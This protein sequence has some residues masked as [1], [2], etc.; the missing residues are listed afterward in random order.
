MAINKNDFIE[1]IDPGL[2]SNKL[3]TQFYYRFKIDGNEYAKLFDYTYKNWD[4]KTRVSKA[5]SDARD[6]RENKVNPIT[7]LDENIKLNAFIQMHF[8]NL[9]N[10]LW[11][12]AKKRHYNNYVSS[13]IG[14]KKVTTIKQMHIKACIKDQI[15]QGLSPRTAK[16]TLELLNPLFN[17]AIVNRL[18]DFNPCTGIK[19]KIPKTKKTVINASEELKKIYETIISIFADDPFYLSFYLL[20]LQGRRKS[21]ILNLKWENIDFGNNRY[22]LEDTKNGEHQMMFLPDA[23]KIEFLKFNNTTGWVYASSVNIG[24]RI[25]NIE[26]QT[27]K[28]KSVI[29]NFTLHYMRNVIVSAMAEQGISATLMSGALGH[30]N[31]STLSNIYL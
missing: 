19:V 1:K 9:P 21:E 4:K 17:E 31:T 18:I 15:N 13:H 25:S 29:Q 11:T 23:V 30:N 3:F 24:E 6:Y 16:T 7:E 5:K 26:K 8:D 27:A 28:I 22:I 12:D 20:A 14:N 10:T 2:K